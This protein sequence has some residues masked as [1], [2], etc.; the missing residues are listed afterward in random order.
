VVDTC[1]VVVRNL[2]A[3]FLRSREFRQSEACGYSKVFQTVA[4]GELGLVAMTR[5]GLGVEI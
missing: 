4:F 5:R 1:E 2:R 3:M